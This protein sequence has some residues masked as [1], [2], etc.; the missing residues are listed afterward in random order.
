MAAMTLQTA[1]T[2][3]IGVGNF[4]IWVVTVEQ[5]LDA[6]GDG[7]SRIHDINQDYLN[8]P[9]YMITHNAVI[10]NRTFPIKQKT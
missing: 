7:T 3:Y 8:Q 9:A 10:H 4:L 5:P 6:Q 2:A 1:G